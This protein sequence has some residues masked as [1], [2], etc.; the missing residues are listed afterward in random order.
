MQ[1]VKE[2]LAGER[3]YRTIRKKIVSMEFVPNEA[4]SESQLAGSIGVSRTPVREAL[5]RLAS[6][7]LVDFRSRAGTIVAPIRI[8]AVRSAQ[9]VREKLEASIIEEAAARNTERSR[10]KLR[11]AI[12]EQRFAIEQADIAMFF[13]SDER[14]H[15]SFAEMA[16]RSHVWSVI[17]DAKKH[18]DRL[19][20]LSL[21]KIELN[22]LLEDHSELFD[23]IERHDPARARRV[24][25]RHLRRVLVQIDELM[26]NY[27]EYFE[28]STVAENEAL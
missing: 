28:G 11:Q 27:P 5:S 14:M 9:F 12:E 3:A 26:A 17:S 7:G 23:A 8:D 13:A 22:L 1:R 24:M 2:L 20:L 21:E 6:E 19:R 15:Q 4:I 16:G 18:M 10:F 25:E